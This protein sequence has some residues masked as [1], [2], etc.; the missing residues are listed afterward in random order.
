MEESRGPWSMRSQPT[1]P[2]GA[3]AG[4]EAV[5]E[6]RCRETEAWSDVVVRLR[7][8]GLMHLVDDVQRQTHDLLETGPHC[9]VVD[10]A[11]VDRLSSSTVA[12]LL[13]VKR[14]CSTRGMAVRLRNASRPVV[15]ELERTGLLQAV[16][17]EPA[18]RGGRRWLTPVQG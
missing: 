9:V 18:P 17:Q 1:R 7:D 15:D 6:V 5:E 10:L 12:A 16:A 11:A 3:V 14:C 13:G 8:L 2:E 4:S